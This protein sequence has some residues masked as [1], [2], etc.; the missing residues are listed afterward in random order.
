MKIKN[1]SGITLITLIIT[2]VI[3]VI[4]VGVGISFGT[5]MT[6]TAKFENIETSLILIQ[7]KI[8]MI[9]DKKAIGDISEEEIY[10]IKQ[11]EGDYAGWYKLEQANLD[12][13][14]LTDLKEDDEYYVYYG[15]KDEATGEY[16]DVDVAYGIGITNDE[17]TYYKLSEILED[18]KG[19][20]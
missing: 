6:K 15:E 16:T 10:G 20:E 12:D 14:G 2:I 4:I 17:K 8:K 19:N 7:S 5:D 13:M 9:A 3:L 1:D 11:E 18:T